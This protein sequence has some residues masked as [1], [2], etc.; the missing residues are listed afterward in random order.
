MEESM[1]NRLEAVKKRFADIEIELADPALNND[2]PK[3][4][5]LSKERASLE[6]ENSQYIRYQK[7]ESDLKDAM[8][9]INGSDAEMAEMMKEERKSIEAEMTSLEATLK[10]ELIPIDPNDKKNI[11]VE[12]RGAVGGDEANIFAGDLLRM[13]TRYAESQ[14][15]QIQYVDGEE[16]A[17]GGY[18]YVSFMVKG[19]NVYSK[20]KFES[21]AHR[22]QRVPK[23]EAAGRI[24][25]STATVLVMPEAEEIDV[26]INPADLKI[27]TYRSQGAG[28]Q[29]VNKTESAVRVTHIPTGIVVSC[30]T[31]KA[32]L[33]NKE[34]CMQMIR[35]K[36]Q[37]YYQSKQDEERSSERKL[38]VGTGERS[39]KIRTYNYPQNRVTDHRIGFTTNTLD[40]VMEGELEPI[41]E[42]LIHYDQEQ[43]ILEEE[44]ADH[45]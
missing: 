19:E 26:K 32:Q 23:T 10:E 25:T 14:G 37:D 39:E 17:A 30:Q 2:I 18:S 11:I 7:L 16:G 8:E 9:I 13:Y 5:A 1:R 31:E 24:H 20:L 29:N 15:W 34:I 12:I 6:D 3:L 27:D 33:Q 40:R 38:K 28:G 45:C 35:A 4:T 41:I 42:A 22:V 36:V 44:H 43:K 21:G